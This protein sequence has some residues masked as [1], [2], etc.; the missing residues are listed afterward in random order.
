[1][2]A[3]IL[4]ILGDTA[5]AHSNTSRHGMN[6]LVPHILVDGGVNSD[7]LSAHSSLSELANHS[8]TT[9]SSSLVATTDS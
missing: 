6:T 9:R 4:A 3:S 5:H 7:V 2:L 1:M 8:H